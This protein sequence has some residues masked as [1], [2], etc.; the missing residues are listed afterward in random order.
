[1][2][3]K[4]AFVGGFNLPLLEARG[5]RDSEDVLQKIIDGT[6]KV[7]ISEEVSLDEVPALHEKFAARQ[8]KGRAV[9]RVGGELNWTS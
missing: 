5:G 8:V 9:I 6:W 4:S 2:I 3:F 1:L 7:P